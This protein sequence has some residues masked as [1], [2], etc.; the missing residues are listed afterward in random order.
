MERVS[1]P[2]SYKSCLSLRE[3][4]TAIKKLKDHFERVLAEKL[5]LSRVSAP[6][7]VRATTGL[8][9]NLNGVEGP[10]SFR[11]KG[12]DNEEST[13]EIVHSLAKWK[14]MALY[15]YGFQSGEGLY[16]DMNAIRKD[17]ELGNVHSIYVDQ[18]DWEKVIDREQRNM[19][20]LQSVVESIYEA[21][22][23][24]EHYIVGEFPHLGKIFP[25][26]IHFLTSQELED[27]YPQLTPKEREHAICRELGAVFIMEIGGLLKS[28]VKH[29]SRAPDYDDWKLNGDILVWYPILNRSIELSSMG[30]RADRDTLLEQL[31]FCN[32]EHRKELE[33]HKL[34]LEE[35]LPFSVGGG[36]GMS[37]ICM[38]M[39]KKAHIGEVQA[40]LWDEETLRV[41]QQAGV[42]LL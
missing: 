35:K 25:E 18:W 2:P 1:I 29:D 10:V 33:F 38:V 5:N 6:L 37:R 23:E 17:E 31:A 24:T 3:T 19:A 13:I 26:K 14:R 28:G 22:K 30:I 39:L 41:C 15:R 42:D 20:T 4:Q 7:F 21:F 27:K 34:L 8:N 36:L 11:S 32:C 9:D 40:S 16:T 12:V